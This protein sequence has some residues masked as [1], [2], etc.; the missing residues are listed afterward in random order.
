MHPCPIY[1][2][3]YKTQSEN[4]IP[5]SE[6]CERGF[7]LLPRL[8]MDT[9]CITTTNMAWVALLKECKEQPVAEKIREYIK[10]SISY[11]G[12]SRLNP[13]FGS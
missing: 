5:I 10:R 2:I 11:P 9:M 12:L 13:R 3:L 7:E 8:N 6:A 1:K 4:S